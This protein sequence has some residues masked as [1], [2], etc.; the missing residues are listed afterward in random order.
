MM[1]VNTRAAFALLREA[2]TRLR[3]GGRVINIST[4]NTVLPNPGVG[5]YAASKAAVEQF[6]AV[7]SAAL[8]AAAPDRRTPLLPCQRREARHSVSVAHRP[9]LEPQVS[10]AARSR[11]CDGG[12]RAA[13]TRPCGCR[14]RTVRRTPDALPSPSCPSVP[15]ISGARTR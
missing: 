11:P 13:A 10:A 6:T 7:A 4:I 3:D 14:P 2:A 5:V 9:I 1:A 15:S 8:T 12:Q